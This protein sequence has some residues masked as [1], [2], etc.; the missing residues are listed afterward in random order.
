MPRAG[1]RP[2]GGIG[3]AVVVV[4]VA[5]VPTITSSLPRMP[6]LAPNRTL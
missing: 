3:G 1:C 4:A 2:P 5:V 6:R